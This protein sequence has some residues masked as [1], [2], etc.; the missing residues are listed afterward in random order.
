MSVRVCAQPGSGYIQDMVASPARGLL[1]CFP[2]AVA[3]SALMSQL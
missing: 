2:P 3:R 1:L